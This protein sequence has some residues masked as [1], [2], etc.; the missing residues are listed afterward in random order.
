MENKS[1]DDFKKKITDYYAGIEY[2]PGAIGEMSE[3]IVNVS[4]KITLEILAQYHKE[5]IEGK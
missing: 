2:A 3:T 4:A 1:F 5:F